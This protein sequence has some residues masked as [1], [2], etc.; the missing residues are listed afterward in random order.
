MK[1]GTINRMRANQ[2]RL[3]TALLSRAGYSLPT[4][5]QRLQVTRGFA[6]YWARKV[7]DPTFKAG[8]RLVSPNILRQ[9]VMADLVASSTR[10]AIKP[11]S[12]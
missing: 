10:S 8:K 11:Q 2:L 1:T 6:R 7:E 5:M 12:D 4:I 3:T 9:H